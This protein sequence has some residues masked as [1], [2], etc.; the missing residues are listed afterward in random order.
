ML[1]MIVYINHNF[2]NVINGGGRSRTYYNPSGYGPDK[3]PLLDPRNNKLRFYPLPV[4][5]LS[6]YFN[7]LKKTT[8]PLTTFTF[9]LN[10]F[11]E[12]FYISMFARP[13]TGLANNHLGMGHR[14]FSSSLIVESII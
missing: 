3:P 10:R 13:F 12:R 5:G 8:T 7:S 14:L 9:R 6:F 4:I 1:V 2:I 11:I